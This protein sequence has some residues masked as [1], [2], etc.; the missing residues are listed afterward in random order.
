[1]E[2]LFHPRCSPGVSL[3][4]L[5]TKFFGKLRFCSDRSV[6]RRPNLDVSL[7]R[8]DH[9]RVELPSAAAPPL[10]PSQG[11]ISSARATTSPCCVSGLRGNQRSH[12]E[13]RC[14]PG[15]DGGILPGPAL[16]SDDGQRMLPPRG[17]RGGS[18]CA[19]F[20]LSLARSRSRRS[21]S[22]RARIVVKSSAARGPFTAFPPIFRF[23]THRRCRQRLRF[24]ANS[25]HRPLRGQA[26]FRSLTN[27]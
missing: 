1:V 13:P 10:S 25:R 19:C 2:I 16:V 12:I 22:R 7:N 27:N 20:P 9:R 5:D 21:S 3:L 23:E 4:C 11:I 18:G 8:A 6:T 24:R 17:G 14:V 26:P 15:P